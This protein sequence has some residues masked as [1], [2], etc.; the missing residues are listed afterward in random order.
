M[1]GEPLRRQDTTS[2]Q[3]ESA[4]VLPGEEA[5]LKEIPIQALPGFATAGP[6][7]GTTLFISKPR[8]REPP[9]LVV[10]PGELKENLV[11]GPEGKEVRPLRNFPQNELPVQTAQDASLYKTVSESP[12]SSQVRKV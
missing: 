7:K 10:P 8:R 4:S 5:H 9:L 1:Q 6:S 12:G 2:A 3:D 11:K